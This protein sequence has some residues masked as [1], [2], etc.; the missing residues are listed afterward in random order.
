MPRIEVRGGDDPLR[1]PFG[2]TQCCGHYAFGG[3]FRQPDLSTEIAELP[4]ADV[5]FWPCTDR[6]IELSPNGR[7]E[8]M[9]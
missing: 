2:H 3:A 7:V 9:S 4:F 1:R 6:A 8:G 5:V